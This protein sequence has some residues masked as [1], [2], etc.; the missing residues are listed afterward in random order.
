MA[1]EPFSFFRLVFKSGGKLHLEM[2][3]PMAKLIHDALCKEGGSICAEDKDL[4]CIDLSYAAEHPQG[5]A[6][7]LDPPCGGPY[8]W[9]PGLF[10]KRPGST[11]SE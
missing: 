8:M 10:T 11:S 2:R 7:A 5:Y 1:D 3:P 4:V 9:V 6:Q